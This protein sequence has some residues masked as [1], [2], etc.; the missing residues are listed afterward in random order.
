MT[1]SVALASFSTIAPIVAVL[2][3]T[4]EDASGGKPLK[5]VRRYA[6]RLTILGIGTGIACISLDYLGYFEAIVGG[7]CSTS[8]SLLLPVLFYG[9]LYAWQHTFT[10]KVFLVVCVG[11]AM[12]MVLAM[13]T[14]DLYNI[15]AHTP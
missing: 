9:K 8:I 10:T 14:M 4:L 11:L 5:G 13:F 2:M 1:C 7:V 12:L 3:E 6:A 15:I